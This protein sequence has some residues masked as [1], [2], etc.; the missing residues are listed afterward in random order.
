MTDFLIADAAIRQLHARYTDA[1]WS[2]DYDSFG[3]CF[4]EDCEWRISGLVLRGRREIVE[5]FSS[6][7]VKFNR[8]LITIRPPI[9]E[10]G[11]GIASGRTYLTEQSV[12]ADGTPLAAIGTYYERFVDQGDRWR[13]SWRL[14]QTQYAGPADFTGRLHSNPEFGPPPGMPPLDATAANHSGHFDQKGQNK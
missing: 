10:V 13:F 14:F 2:K 4:S 9:L 12:L 7:M 5:T 11:D 1:G 8:V 3:D 6:L